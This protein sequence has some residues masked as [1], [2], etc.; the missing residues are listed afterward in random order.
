MGTQECREQ[1]C[2]QHDPSHLGGKPQRHRSTLNQSQPQYPKS[3]QN[4]DE[5]AEYRKAR[6][7]TL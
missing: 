6:I 7:L 4:T 5:R 1:S 2:L 3:Q